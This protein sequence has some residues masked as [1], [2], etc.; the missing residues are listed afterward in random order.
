L[1]RLS[2]FV[3]LSVLATGLFPACLYDPNDRCGPNQVS[4][5]ND[6]CECIDGFVPGLSGC[7][8]CGDHELESAG[9]CVCADGYA[10]ANDAAACQPIPESLGT[11]CDLESAPC[12]AGAYPLCHLTEAGIGYC[13]SSCSDD[14]DCDGG[15]KCHID[16]AA[17]YCRRPP[18]GYGDHCSA[19]AECA[20]GEATF[21]E[22]IQSQLCLVP[23]T[24]A[25]GEVC[26]EGE[27]CCDFALFRPICVPENACAAKG[28]SE[29]GAQ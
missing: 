22:T 7:V 24:A 11:A 25:S 1:K 26:F 28:G 29:L 10:R 3:W 14:A 21:C 27:V 13:T 6:R 17:S 9:S 23:C 18:L 16:G 4:V 15:Y 12:A 8:A 5:D 2:G 19:D 20:A